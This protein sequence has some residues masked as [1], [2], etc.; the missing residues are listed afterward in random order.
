MRRPFRYAF[1][2]LSLVWAIGAGVYTHN[3]DVERAQ[4][5]AKFSYDVCAYGK[6]V[7]HETDLSS[8]D[9][10][11]SNTLKVWMEGSSGNVL[12]TS[13]APIPFAWLA[14]FILIYVGRAQLVGFRAVVPWATLSRPKKLFVVFCA[15][16]SV[17]SMLFGV[18]MLL[19]LY[20]D[21]KVRVTPGPP[22]EVIKSGEDFVTVKGTWTRTDLT[23]DT[24][25]NPL[26]T[27]N[28]ECK[29]EEKRCVEALAY[30]SDSVLLSDVVEYDIQSWTS[31]AIVLR[32][33]FPCA[34]E[35]FT[36]DLNT[37]TVSGAGKRINEKTLFCK[38]VSPSGS[39]NERG[40][41]GYRLSNGF[42][43]YWELRQKARP[44][45]LRVV[46]SVFGN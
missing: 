5:S 33:D 21:T 7:N 10:E 2:L 29:K 16:A 30:V 42:Q 6:E 3:A 18:V 40:A 14:G 11:R 22:V 41:W 31:D 23:N 39:E 38:P 12:T 20:V 1:L 26:Q 45:L 9:A 32:R 15:F 4:H 28:I 43:T 8:C 44:L 46:Q 13:L 24:I 25:A 36:V 17:A 37:K 35:I 27:S 34:T 19:N